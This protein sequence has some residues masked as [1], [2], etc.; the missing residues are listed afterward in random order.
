MENTVNEIEAMSLALAMAARSAETGNVPVGAVVLVGGEVVAR[1]GNL[2]ETLPDPTAHAEMLAL[3]EASQRLGRWRL[4]D[5]T[6]VVTLEPC[7]MCAGALTQAR[8]KRVVYACR[9]PKAGAV[10]TMFGVGRDAR[11]NHVYEV[12]EGVLADE[13]GAL[14]RGF[15]EKLRKR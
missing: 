4:E 15:F 3:R 6:M 7:A 1:A 8:V 2:R 11:L 5:A 14:L 13:C 9:D 10:D 12:S